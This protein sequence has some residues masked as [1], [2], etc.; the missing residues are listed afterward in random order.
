MYNNRKIEN[1]L[2]LIG[3]HVASE[4]REFRRREHGFIFSR[5]NSLLMTMSGQRNDS[6]TRNKS[7]DNGSP[8]WNTAVWRQG[9]KM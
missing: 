8:W 7:A 2:N 4:G 5:E 9:G 3:L 6:L 1:R